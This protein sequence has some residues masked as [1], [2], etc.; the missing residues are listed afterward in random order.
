MKFAADFLNLL[1]H[2]DF[3]MAFHADK[4]I[5]GHGDGD[6]IQS[7]GGDK[8][9]GKAIFFLHHAGDVRPNRPADIPGKI[10]DAVDESLLILWGVFH[11]ESGI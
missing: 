11:A 9:R 10:Q 4:E 2:R 5:P 1:R 6:E 8:E 7:C 3:Q